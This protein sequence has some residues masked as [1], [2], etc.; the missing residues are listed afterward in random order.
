[1]LKWCDNLDNPIQSASRYMKV[2]CNKFVFVSNIFCDQNAVI[3]GGNR[4]I[5]VAQTIAVPS[6]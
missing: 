6:S 5:P 1:M 2:R 4:L 3:W